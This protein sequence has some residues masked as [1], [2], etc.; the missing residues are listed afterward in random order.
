MKSFNLKKYII[1][2][3][4]LCAASIALSAITGC[5]T[6][7]IEYSSVAGH[8]QKVSLLRT[9][10]QII[11]G[12][13]QDIKR[14]FFVVSAV[15]F[16]QDGRKNHYLILVPSL[17]SGSNLKVEDLLLQYDYPY[18]IQGQN[19]KDLLSGLEKCVNEWDSAN[20]NYSGSVYSFLISSAQDAKT[21]FNGGKSYE[22]TPYIR[23]NYSKTLEGAIAR[24][25]LGS[26]T[27]EI[28]YST[29][30]GKTVKNKVLYQDI[31][32]FSMFDKFEQIKDFQDLIS[33]GLVDLKEKGMEAGGKK[34]EVK[35]EDEQQVKTESA[36]AKKKKRRR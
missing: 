22:T 32:K 2:F 11:R 4:S 7:L 18:I 15:D 33:K 10:M 29:T 24:L 12:D 3:C 17:A 30:D 28:F 23:F 26:R 31:E 5:A 20:I 16:F 19:I 8:E 25:A 9:E 35:A 21:W 1:C 36:P 13:N 6:K 34:T 14:N 27:E